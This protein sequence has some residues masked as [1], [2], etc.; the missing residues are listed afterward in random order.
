MINVCGLWLILCLIQF[1]KRSGNFMKRN[2]T[3]PASDWDSTLPCDYHSDRCDLTYHTDRRDLTCHTDRRDL[4]YRTDRYDSTYRTD[5]CDSTYHT[6]RRDST[7]VLTDVTSLTILTDVTRLTIL[8]DVTCLLTFTTFSVIPL[9]RWPR[10]QGQTFGI[11]I[12]I[13]RLIRQPQV[14]IWSWISKC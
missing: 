8:T 11:S 1:S 3:H 14:S 7:Y 9:P 13:V 5:R 10:S 6:D 4:T 12:I 2:K